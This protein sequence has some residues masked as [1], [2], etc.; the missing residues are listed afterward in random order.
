MK[1]RKQRVLYVTY[2]KPT[3]I[4]VLYTI[5]LFLLLSLAR[6]SFLYIVFLN[7]YL[8]DVCLLNKFSQTALCD[9]FF[10]PN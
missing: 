7:Q 4:N 5:N 1:A 2:L 10:I 8:P 6:F 3:N 9:R